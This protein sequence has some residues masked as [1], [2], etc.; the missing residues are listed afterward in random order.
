ML[1]VL[2]SALLFIPRAAKLSIRELIVTD[3]RVVRERVATD[4]PTRSVAIYD[5]EGEL[6]FGAAPELDRY[7]D[8]V[9]AA[10]RSTGIRH[11]VLRLKRVRSPDAVCLERLELAL[12]AAQAK[13]FT[14]YL[15]GIRPDLQRG[16]ERLGWSKWLPREQWFLEEDAEFSA[17]LKAVRTAYEAAEERR[18]TGAVVYYLV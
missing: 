2:A 15:A 3:E 10:A 8:E 14:V 11:I 6:F 7:L 1:G 16:F 17:T 12:Q 9:F 18:Q 13:G 5:L 4:P